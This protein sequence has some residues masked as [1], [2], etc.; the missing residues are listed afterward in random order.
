L[1]FGGQGFRQPG[2]RAIID[3]NWMLCVIC[4][5]LPICLMLKREIETGRDK[6]KERKKRK[7]ERKRKEKKKKMKLVPLHSDAYIFAGL[8]P[9]F[10]HFFFFFFLQKDFYML[11]ANDLKVKQHLSLLRHPLVEKETCDTSSSFS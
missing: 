7:K 6:K 2:K 9:L 5:V 11:H 10:L 3:S 8:Q 4:T 1:A